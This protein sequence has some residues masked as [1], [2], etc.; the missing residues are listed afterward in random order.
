MPPGRVGL[1][2]TE[3]LALAAIGIA[4]ALG[5]RALLAELHRFEAAALTLLGLGILALSISMRRVFGAR[6]GGERLAIT[7]RAAYM[8]SLFLAIAA[9]MLPSRATTGAAI[10]M[11]EI[12]IV[13]DLFTR[14]AAR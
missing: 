4:L 7:L 14:F 8:T 3:G 2:L 12:A 10:A 1:D 6:R 13:F 5:G 11:V 9:V